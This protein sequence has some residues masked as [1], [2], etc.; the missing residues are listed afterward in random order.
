[1]NKQSILDRFA[2]DVINAPE[3]VTGGGGKNKAKKNGKSGR[4]TK[5]GSGSG[6]K[7]RSGRGVPHSCGRPP[8]A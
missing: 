5:S 7:S 6:S 8:A 4:G 1:M 2:A 3:A